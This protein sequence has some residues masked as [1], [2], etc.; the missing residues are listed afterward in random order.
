M[1]HGDILISSQIFVLLRL[2]PLRQLARFGLSP[3]LNRALLTREQ[4]VDRGISQV[5]L[6]RD[7]YRI[8]RF[9]ARDVVRLSKRLLSHFGRDT[10]EMLQNLHVRDGIE[11]DLGDFE[12]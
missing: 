6:R 12:R 10:L 4:Q 1:H 5:T 7:D 3:H 2:L 8:Y 11:G 9:T